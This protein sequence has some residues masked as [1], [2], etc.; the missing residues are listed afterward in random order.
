MTALAE[1]HSLPEPTFMVQSWPISTPRVKK[2]QKQKA[3]RLFAG[4]GFLNGTIEPGYFTTGAGATVFFT[5]DFLTALLCFFVFTETGFAW[6]VAAAGG[7]AAGVCAANI[8]AVAN[9]IVTSVFFMAFF[10][11]AGSPPAY[12]S[13]LGLAA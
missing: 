10:S 12:N 7:L 9:A 4:R 13:I 1:D 2:S 8:E 11:L 6:V 5:A 3:P